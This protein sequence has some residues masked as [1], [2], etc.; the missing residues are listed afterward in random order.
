MHPFVLQTFFVF[1]ALIL[2]GYF[3]ELPRYIY[4][5]PDKSSQSPFNNTSMK[6]LVI[7]LDPLKPLH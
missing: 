1:M 6:V 5:Y 2:D 3:E 4:C 7:W